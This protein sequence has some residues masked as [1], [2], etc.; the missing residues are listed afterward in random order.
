MRIHRDFW[1]DIDWKLCNEAVFQVQGMIAEAYMSGNLAEVA[2]LQDKLIRMFEARVLAVKKVL[3]NAGHKT[4][5]VDG[6]VW[7]DN[8]TIW[9]VIDQLRDLSEYRPQPVKR[10]YIP[11]ASGGQRPL[12]IPTMYDR[13]VQTLF[14][15]ALMPIAEC[16]ADSRS[17]GYRPYRS[18]H[19]AAVYLKLVLGAMYAKRWV[20]EADFSMFFDNISHDW[21]LKNIP[22]NTKILNAFLKAGFLDLQKMEYHETSLGTPQGGSIS[23]T[24]ANMVLDGLEK[25]LGDDF[26]VVRYADDFVVIGACPDALKSEAMPIIVKFLAERGLTLNLDKTRITSIE[27]GFDFLGF[28]FREYKDQARVIGYKKGIFLVKPAKK[29]IQAI[30]TKS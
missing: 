17:F 7:K 11:K 20:L 26:R 16:S 14:V 28:N 18:A 29:N 25:A 3:T 23:P 6:V 21:L 10:V 5:G 4:P 8:E 2:H 24:I 22:I 15:F 1:K 13:A 27:D 12:G 30:R 9:N 19:D